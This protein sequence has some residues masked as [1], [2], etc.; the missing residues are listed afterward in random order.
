MREMG[1]RLAI[2]APPRSLKQLILR[3]V[4]PPMV[5]GI[6]IGLVATQWLRRIAEAQLY[7]VNARDPITLVIAA[8][9]VAAAAVLAAYLPAR[10]ASRVDPLVVLR[11]E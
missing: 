1:V 9:T 7:E 8:I 2:G 11:A 10:R 3:Q 5:L 6:F 4:V